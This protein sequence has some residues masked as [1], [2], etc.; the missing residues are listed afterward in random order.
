MTMRL[1]ASLTAT[2]AVVTFVV[3]S[4]SPLQGQAA[5]SAP[6]ALVITAT[7]GKP[8]DYKAPRTR[9][10]RSAGDGAGRT[11]AALSR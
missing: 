7:G 11:A 6:P 4:G 2:A 8:V 5:R 10:C 1:F 9:C 3:A